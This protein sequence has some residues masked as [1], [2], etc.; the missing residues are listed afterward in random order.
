V[1]TT[2]ADTRTTAASNYRA[3]YYDST[4]GRFI[5][6]DS[7]GFKAGE[8][9]YVYVFNAPVNHIDPSGHDNPGC[10]GVPHKFERPCILECCAIHDECYDKNQC[11]AASWCYLWGKC[12]ECNSNVTFCIYQCRGHADRDDPK[13]PNCYYAKLHKFGPCPWEPGSPAPLP[14]PT[15]SPTPKPSTPTPKK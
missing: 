7:I 6:E 10:D 4:I 11:T 15:R 5:S 14:T 2:Q 3:R 8:N 12:H 13:R 9:F 1:P